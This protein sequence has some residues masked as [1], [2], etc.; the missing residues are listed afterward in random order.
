MNIEVG[1]VSQETKG[2]KLVSEAVPP[3]SGPHE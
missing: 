1:K 2:I 3:N